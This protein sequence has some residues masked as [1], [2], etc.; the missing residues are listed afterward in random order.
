MQTR[1]GSTHQSSVRDRTRTCRAPT[2][3]GPSGSACMGCARTRSLGRTVDVLASLHLL[4]IGRAQG[5]VGKLSAS[6]IRDGRARR[7]AGHG[8]VGVGSTQN[9][10]V[11]DPC[12]QRAPRLCCARV[13]R[14][15]A[16]D[17]SVTGI[18][19]Y[20]RSGEIM[21]RGRREAGERI[22]RR[23]A[24]KGQAWP[25]TSSSSLRCARRAPGR[26]DEYIRRQ[27]QSAHSLRTKSSVSVS[28]QPHHRG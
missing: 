20:E 11:S 16:G 21:W 25:R 8:W 19:T 2:S 15:S 5:V 14:P 10:P 12:S 6:G 18:K 13:R 9:T 3:A 17:T 28:P 27:Q 26:A 4:E 7:T 22:L 23:C 1:E 24:R